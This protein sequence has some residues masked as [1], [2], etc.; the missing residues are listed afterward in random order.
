MR[1]TQRRAEGRPGQERSD[2]FARVCGLRGILDPHLRKGRIERQLS[3]H[4]RCV[5]V[6]DVRGDAA[7]LE[8]IA[9]E[10][11]FRQVGGGVDSFQNLNA[12]IAPIAS[13][14]TPERPATF[15]YETLSDTSRVMSPLMPTDVVM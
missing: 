14:F 9:D 3:R 7:M 6:E 2:D 4:A 8:R 1:T 11:R 15:T 13:C 5:R 10:M 12:T